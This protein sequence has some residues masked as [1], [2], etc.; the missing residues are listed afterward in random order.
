MFP[1]HAQL[2]LHRKTKYKTHF[3]LCPSEMK[4]KCKISA[5]LTLYGKI[6]AVANYTRHHAVTCTYS[7]G[8]FIPH[9]HFELYQR[10][11]IVVPIATFASTA[12]GKMDMTHM[13]R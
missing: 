1:F 4:P 10:T 13:I 6:S 11:S 5:Y 12:G 9:M 7:K 8:S 2:T 3:I